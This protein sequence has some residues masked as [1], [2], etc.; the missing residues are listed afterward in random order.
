M[1]LST[2][3]RKPRF[4]HSRNDLRHIGPMQNGLVKD[5]PSAESLSPDGSMLGRKGLGG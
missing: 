5:G 1:G 3:A 4:D 2:P